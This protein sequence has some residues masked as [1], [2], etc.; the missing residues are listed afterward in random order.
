MFDNSP[1]ITIITAC[2]NAASTIKDCLLSVNYQTYACEHII[3]DGASTDG[4]QELVAKLACPH[5]KMISEPDRGLYDA[6]NKGL[7]LATGDVVGILHADDFYAHDSVLEHVARTFRAQNVD[8]CYGDLLYVDPANLRKA[9]RSWKSVPYRKDRF[10]WGWMPPHPTFFVRKSIYEAYGDFNLGLGTSADY[11]LM[12]RFLFKYGISAAYLPETLVIMRAGGVS[13]RSW[14]NRLNAHRMD[15]KAWKING[16]NPM[17][18]T[19]LAKPLSK[20]LQF[21]SRRASKFQPAI[22]WWPVD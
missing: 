14:R 7:T 5:A 4:T 10:H 1:T 20:L 6:L 16:L 8:S 9:V 18:W 11:E 2:R 21:S 3:I 19:L 17:P 22:P 15:R 13:N 12:L